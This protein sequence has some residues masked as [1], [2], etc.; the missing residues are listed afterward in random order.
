MVGEERTVDQFARDMAITRFALPA[1]VHIPVA[2]K[3]EA[4][5]DR[6]IGRV[7]DVLAPGVPNQALL[8]EPYYIPQNDTL[9]IWDLP[10][11]AILHNRKQV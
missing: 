3:E 7:V 5:I 2:A 4:D 11:S 1:S 8:V 6:Y 9:P 10:E